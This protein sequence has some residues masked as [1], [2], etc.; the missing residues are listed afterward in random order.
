MSRI[1]EPNPRRA[2]P[3]I[4][5][6][7]RLSLDELRKS[8]RKV[9]DLV[10]GNPAQV[11]AGT[12]A[13]VAKLA[14]VSQPTVIRFCTAVGCTGFHDFRLRLAQSVALGTPATHSVIRA[15]DPP[16]AV[17]EKI[18]EYTMTSLDW[19]RHHLDAAALGAAIELLAAARSITFFGFG[20][21]AIVAQDAEQKFPLFGV[22]C[23]ALADNHQQVMAAAM[24]GP[25][26][27]VIAISNTGQSHG[28][29]EAAR[30][31]RDHGARTI[32]LTGARAALSDLC[33]ITL[34][35]ETLDNTDAFTPTTSRVA[36]LVIIDVLSTAVALRRHG[37]QMDRMRDMKMT[38]SHFRT[39]PAS[40]EEDP[41]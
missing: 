18:F 31:A 5:E 21:S 1:P 32:A 7:V 15:D 8:E 3:N 39:G 16:S 40:S 4:L 2:G 23:R 12:V 28:I 6:V 14:D 33:D 30:I 27:V 34:L 36:A 37:D 41:D 24:M 38:L 35:V 10:L 29:I 22:P 20:A 11:L 9:A 25:E 13:E 17:V 19:A 26:D